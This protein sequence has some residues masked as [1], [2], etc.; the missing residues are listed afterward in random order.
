[1]L[2]YLAARPARV[3][4][5]DLNRAHVALTRLKLAGIRRLPTYRDF[6]RFFGEADERANV[7]AFRQFIA[8]HLDPE[9]AAFWNGRSVQGRRR[10][11]L[12]RRNI[13][14]RGLL[15]RFIGFGHGLARLYGLDLRDFLAARTI[16]QQ[17]AFFDER[18]APLFDRKLV[19]WLSR[20]PASLFGLGIPPA[21]YAELAAGGD[22]AQV[23]RQ[24]LERLAC[25]FPLREN[26]FAWQA[27]NRGYAPAGS[28]P[29][30]PYLQERHYAAIREGA[31]RVEVKRASFTD[32]LKAMPDASA[33]RYVL[34]DAQ[35]WMKPEQ[36]DALWAEITRTARPQAR[37]I[38]RT[39]GEASILPGRL[40][41]RLLSGWRYEEE[42]SRALTRGDRSSIYGGFHLYERNG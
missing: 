1:V 41:P 30:P 2:S 31:L 28:G 27:F 19:R 37:V 21:Q 39:A 32:A 6:Y 10:I 34:L 4:A 12:F 22:V 15:G 5:V 26:Y 20:R 40:S 7:D 35:D 9:T 25:D 33:D 17:R 16:E 38:F 29:L 36:L 23:L 11:S 24:R 14:R 18:I 8:P 42:R 13:Y 3:T